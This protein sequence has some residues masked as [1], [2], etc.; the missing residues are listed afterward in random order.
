MWSVLRA[1]GGG[2]SKLSEPLLA[3]RYPVKSGKLY[4]LKTRSE[5]LNEWQET[6]S[7]VCSYCFHI[8]KSLQVGEA[9]WARQPMDPLSPHPTLEQ[10]PS[11]AAEGMR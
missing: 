6:L 1:D 2:P 7:V 4:Q 8:D 11:N 5:K 9:G 3:Q 10:S